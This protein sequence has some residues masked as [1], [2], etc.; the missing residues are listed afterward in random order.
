MNKN[1]SILILTALSFIFTACSVERNLDKNLSKLDEL[2]GT[3]DNPHRRF[4]EAQLKVC[5]DRERSSGGEPIDLE[6]FNVSELIRGGGS[7]NNSYEPTINPILWKS[8][9]DKL[10]AYSLKIADFNGGYIETDWISEKQTDKRCLIK[11]QI[12]SKEL[13]TSGINSQLIC[14]NLLDDTWINDNLTYSE[15]SKRLTLSILE[16]TKNFQ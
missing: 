5:R 9:I 1:L 7:S 10:D 13:M 4:T 11:I 3:C 2:Y 8:A 14:Q 6:G 12:T 16:N 15:E